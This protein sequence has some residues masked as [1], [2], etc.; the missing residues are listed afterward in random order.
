M[1]YRDMKIEI[2]VTHL[3]NQALLEETARLATATRRTVATLI[4]ALAEVDARKLWADVGCSS[5]YTYCTQVL[6]FSEQ[7]A[8]LRMEAARVVRQFPVVLEML[9]DGEITLTN[10]GLLKPHL[11]NENHIQLLAAARGKSKREVARQ[12]AALSGAPEQ[13]IPSWI[14]PL[15]DDRFWISF[16]IG[17]QTYER[18]QRATD[19]L[20]HAVPDG[21]LGRVFD[22]ALISLL[23]DLERSKFGATDAPRGDFVS[24][25]DSRYIA[26]SVRRRVWKRDG[27][28]CAFVGTHGR[29]TETAFLEFHHIKPFACGGTST[30]DNIELRCRA[31]NQREAELFFEMAMPGVVRERSDCF[32]LGPDLVGVVCSVTSGCGSRDYVAWF[33]RGDLRRVYIP[34]ATLARHPNAAIQVGVEALGSIM[35]P[36]SPPTSTLRCARPSGTVP[37][38]KGVSAAGR[39]QG[40][41]GIDFAHLHRLHERM[42]QPRVAN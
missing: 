32:G 35:R 16:E 13:P 10:V 19:L 18:L 31:H 12:M 33:H 15:S 34:Q 39:L 23:R 3:S 4:A 37:M 1:V 9:A 8:Y 36:R 21:N 7:E 28:R 29:C 6:G 2:P 17:D 41:K 30:L 14:T 26:A 22:R 40:R 5:L 27:G 20:R 24:E 11:T 42:I 38:E 25:S